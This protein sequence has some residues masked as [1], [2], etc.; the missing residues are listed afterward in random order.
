MNASNL[1]IKGMTWRWLINVIGVIVIVILL[2][3]IVAIFFISDSYYSAVRSDMHSKIR[4]GIGS[5]Q[6]K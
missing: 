3:Q 1:K 6:C 5:V 2:I 4:M